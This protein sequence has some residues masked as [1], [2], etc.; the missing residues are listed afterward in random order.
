MRIDKFLKLS[1]IIKR[2]TL[3][4]EACDN[5]RVFINE[6]IAKAGDEVNAGDVIKINF[7]NKVLKLKVIDDGEKMVNPKPEQLYILS[8]ED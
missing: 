1:R 6:K 8:S 7:S 4:K 2:R 3:A 5:K